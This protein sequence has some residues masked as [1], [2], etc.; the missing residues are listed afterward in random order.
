VNVSTRRRRVV[1]TLDCAEVNSAE[2][3]RLSQLAQHLDAELEA[4]FIEDL[5]VLRA[6]DLPFVREFRFGSLQLERFDQER[7]ATELRAAARR[8]EASLARH[9]AL[10]LVPWHFRVWR[11]SLDQELLTVLEADVLA[12]NRPRPLAGA[13]AWHGH[14]GAVAVCY[15]A[16]ERGGR[17]LAAAAALALAAQARLTVLLPGDGR[18]FDELKRQVENAMPRPAPPVDIVPL[19]QG[20]P[21]AMAGALRQAGCG[22][23][24]VSRTGAVLRISSLRELSAALGCTIIVV[25]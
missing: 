24:V 8:A 12:V 17:A 4:V 14:Q 19:G 16:D 6:A 21:S 20:R 1:M 22:A 18:S 2:L 10:R 3:V 11:G 23:L 13:A 5:D 25:N 7:L 9:A 15:D